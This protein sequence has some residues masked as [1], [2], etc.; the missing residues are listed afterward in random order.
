MKRNENNA[1]DTGLSWPEK[2]FP[3]GTDQRKKKKQKKKD[4]KKELKS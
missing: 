1:S 3:T 2:K 4:E